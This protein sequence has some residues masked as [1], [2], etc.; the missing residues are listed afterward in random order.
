MKRSECPCQCHTN[1]EIVHCVPC[2]EPDDTE[3]PL[4]ILYRS[5]PE[6]ESLREWIRDRDHKVSG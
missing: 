5:P 1:V 4:D 3:F 6:A 2:C